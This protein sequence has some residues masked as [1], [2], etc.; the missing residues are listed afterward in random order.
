MADIVRYQVMPPLSAEEYQELYE[1]IKANGVLVPIVVDEDEVIIDGHHRAKIAA[2]LGIP[3]PEE[4]IED[5]SESEK[6]NMAFTLNLKRRHLNREQ[7]RALIAESLKADPQLSNREHER[8]TGSHKNTIQSV[9]E[10]LES[11]GQIAQSETRLSA[12]G[13]ER[14]SSQPRRE[15]EP[16]VPEQPEPTE[17]PIGNIITQ[18][19]LAELN[20]PVEKPEP[21]KTEPRA[22]AITSQFT[23]AIA[24]LNRVLNK[25]DRITRDKNFPRNKEKVAAMHRNDLI[26]AIDEL[27]TLVDNTN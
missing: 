11:T 17:T 1:D 26:R 24:D 16:V 25:F 13:R 20:Q 27:Q 8:R 22:E 19:D 5:K 7:R 21:H 23:S 15:P 4:M 14:P 2:E 10:E 6:R 9:R 18:D 3:C 12:D